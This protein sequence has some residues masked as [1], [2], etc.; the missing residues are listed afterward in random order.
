MKRYL[1][2]H[3]EHY[4]PGGGWSDYLEQTDDLEM[5]KFLAKVATKYGGWFQIV[6]T[7]TKEIINQ[8]P[9]DAP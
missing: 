2:F 4:Y 8:T 7:H 6:D 3:G 1:V 5:A 9:F